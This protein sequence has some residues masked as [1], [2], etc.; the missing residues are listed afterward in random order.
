VVAG[1]EGETLAP[2]YSLFGKVTSGMS[3]IQQINAG[4]SS[5]GTPT[6]LHRMISVTVVES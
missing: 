3:V 2:K 6:T 5:S 1:S 4:G